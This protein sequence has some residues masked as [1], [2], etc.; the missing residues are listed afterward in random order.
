MK[1]AIK[2]STNPSMR[3]S[4]SIPTSA[5]PTTPERQ[6]QSGPASDMEKALAALKESQE[7]LNKIRIEDI[8]ELCKEFIKTVDMAKRAIQLQEERE[9]TKK[10]TKS[11]RSGLKRGASKKID[12][13]T[14]GKIILNGMRDAEIT[15]ADDELEF[16]EKK[17]GT[18]KEVED[19]KFEYLKYLVSHVFLSELK[20]IQKGEIKS[21]F[22]DRYIK[23]YGKCKNELYSEMRLSLF[24]NEQRDYLNGYLQ[25]VFRANKMDQRGDIDHTLINYVELVMLHETTLRIVKYVHKFSTYQ[26]TLAFMEKKSREAYGIFDD[27]DD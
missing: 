21:A 22:H 7:E 10:P 12:E 18:V 13:Y 2:A 1:T 8:R 9:S 16:L 23:L 17:V 6:R 19:L 20:G 26:E 27:E 4:I 14:Q 3:T 15:F 5:S 25:G 24:T 11:T